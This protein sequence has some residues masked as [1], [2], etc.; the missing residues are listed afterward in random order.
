[1]VHSRQFAEEMALRSLA[2]GGSHLCPSSG[3]WDSVFD[4][5]LRPQLPSAA[6]PGGS[7]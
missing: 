1:M 5:G 7:S 3:H 2:M 6:D 4:S